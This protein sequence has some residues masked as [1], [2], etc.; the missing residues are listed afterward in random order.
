MLKS[1]IMGGFLSHSD[2]TIPMVTHSLRLS[3][4]DVVSLVPNIGAETFIFCMSGPVSE[5]SES[6]NGGHISMCSSY[7]GRSA[8]GTDDPI[9]LKFLFLFDREVFAQ[10]IFR[11]LIKTPL[12][13]A[14]ISL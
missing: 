11:I 2:T 1:T 4:D 12:N 3:F 6:T 9:F 5:F 13:M 10:Q 8:S 7:L 14:K